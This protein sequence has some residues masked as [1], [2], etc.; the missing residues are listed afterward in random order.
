MLYDYAIIG[1]GP[2]GLALAQILSSHGKTV[3]LFERAKTLGGCHRITRVP[4]AGESLFAHHS[5]VIYTDAY[6][7]FKTLLKNMGT[8]FDALFTPYKFPVSQIGGFSA[9]KFKIHELAAFLVAFLASVIL[10][11][12]SSASMNDFMTTFRFSDPSRDFVNRL[13]LLTDGA[14]ADR[15]TLDEF[16]S[17]AEQLTGQTF[18]P[19]FPHDS[20]NGLFT[21]W[22]KTLE[23][24][25]VTVFKACAVRS[26]DGSDTVQSIDTEKGRFAATNYVLAMP[27]EQQNALLEH[28]IFKDAFGPIEEANESLPLT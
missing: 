7:N 16:M 20:P 8:S 19:R 9:S 2:T 10:P 25:G 24:R 12:S 4:V 1:G 28:G 13:C 21:V 5:P 27:P 18:Q 26:L 3:I 6:K 11:F 23:A 17:L 15:Y 14:A 22:E